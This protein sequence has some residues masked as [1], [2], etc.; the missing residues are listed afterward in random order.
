MYINVFAHLSSFHKTSNKSL[1]HVLMG[2]SLL[3]SAE[4]H[5]KIVCLDAYLCPIPKFAFPHE[6]VEY[7]NTLGED[8][9][10]ER[11]KDAT[12][13]ISTRAPISARTL[14]YCPSLELINLNSSGVNF[15]DIKV[16]RERNITVLNSP[17]GS[18]ESVAEHAFAL[19]FAAKRRIVEG[20][21]LTLA[22]QEWPK[23]KSLMSMYPHT[24]RISRREILGVVGYGGLGM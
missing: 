17:S 11:M 12:I 4:K 1:F 23:G 2:S 21:N 10:I 22:A 8:L 24:P 20:H 18:A 19:Y 3:S 5:P 9:T 6:Y 16:C 14:S 7:D 15:V 13:V